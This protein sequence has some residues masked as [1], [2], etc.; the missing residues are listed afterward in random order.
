MIAV[1]LAWRSWPAFYNGALQ[2]GS[3]KFKHTGVSRETL[4]IPSDSRMIRASFHVKQLKQ[5]NEYK[6]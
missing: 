6:E 4:D 3:G 5:R 2:P 1:I